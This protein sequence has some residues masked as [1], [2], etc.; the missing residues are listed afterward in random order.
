MNHGVPQMRQ[1]NIFLLTRKDLK[2]KWEFPEEEPKVV[3]LKEAIRIY[4]PLILC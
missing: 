4:L 1:R 3:T 2:I